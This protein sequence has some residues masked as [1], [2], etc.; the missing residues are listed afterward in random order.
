M[1]L[2]LMRETASVFSVPEQAENVTALR[3]WHCKY[4]S[5]KAL[6]VFKN[7]EELMIAGYPDSSLEVL[8]SLKKLKFLSILHMPKN[9]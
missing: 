9:F 8:Q 7:L 2:D 1:Y 4:K 3:I 5:L 6:S